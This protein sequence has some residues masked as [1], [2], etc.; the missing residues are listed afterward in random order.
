MDEEDLVVHAATGSIEVGN[1][2]LDQETSRNIDFSVT[3]EEDSSSAVINV[4]YN[5]FKDY[6]ALGNTG[7]EVDET[8]VLAYVQDDA[9]FY[10][11]E[12]E[13][14]FMVTAVAGGDLGLR[15]NGDMVRGE[16]DKLGDV[17]RLPPYR[18]GAELNW[19]NDRAFTY[20]RVLTAD[21]QDKPGENEL[22]TDGYTRWDAGVDTRFSV[23]SRSDLTLFLKFKNITDEEIRMSTSFLRDVAPEPGRSVEA[24]LRFTF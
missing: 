1:P 24:G 11:A 4:F 16:L 19:T 22:E 9:E 5:D 8:P 15:I 20:L 13:V 12:V 6:I 18:V 17:P 21:D 3:W 2:D 23:G 7:V 14:N 10:G